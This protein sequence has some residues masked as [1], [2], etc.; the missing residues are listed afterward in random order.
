MNKPKNL[1]KNIVLITLLLLAVFLVLGLDTRLKTVHY[2]FKSQ[3]LEAPV[4]I[5]LVTDLHSCNYGIGQ[6]V[7]L[8]AID[9]EKP[10]LVL[11]GGDIIDDQLPQ[12]KALEFLQ[13]VAQKYPTF[14]VSGN[15][16]YWTR[17]IEEI[18]SIVRR[19]NIEV[20]EGTT[21]HWEKNG[22]RFDLSGIDDKEKMNP[23]WQEQLEKAAGSRRKNT[24]SVLLTHRP[25]EIALYADHRYDLVLAGHAHGGQW[26][27]P[28]LCNGLFAPDQG[29]FPRYAGGHYKIEETDLVVSRGLAKESTRVPRFF[30]RPE[31]VMVTLEKT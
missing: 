6:R 13:Q 16:E 5:A 30:N 10:D 26:R 14:Y 8:N 9:K 20:L 7:L 18:K 4:K 11:L 27:L 23:E 21:L 17:K 2:R 25:E 15:H 12:Q 19:F 3:R 31:L 1:K 24:F 29:F 28:F 22:Q